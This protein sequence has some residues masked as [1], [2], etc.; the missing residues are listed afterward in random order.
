MTTQN[1]SSIIPNQWFTV[2]QVS[3]LNGEIFNDSAA[4]TALFKLNFNLSDPNRTGTADV[5]MELINTPNTPDRVESADRV[6]I[7]NPSTNLVVTIDGI[8]YRLEVSWQNL[9]PST[10]MVSGNE[11][12]VFEGAMATGV[13]RARFFSD[14]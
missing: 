8:N 4:A 2:A 6:K 12:Y 9:D 3:L 14:R 11:F 10:G 13:L 1:F 5:L 7:T